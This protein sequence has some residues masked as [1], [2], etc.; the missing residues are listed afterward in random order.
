MSLNKTKCTKRK[1]KDYL[2]GSLLD[3]KFSLWYSSYKIQQKEVFFMSKSNTSS[4]F[5]Q[6][7]AMLRTEMGLTQAELAEELSIF[8]NREKQLSNLTISSYEKG[9]KTPPL[10]MVVFMAKY[11][12]CSTDYLLGSEETDGKKLLVKRES[13]SPL[14]EPDIKIRVQEFRKYHNNPVFVV[15]SNST[16]QNCWAILD[17]D[18]RRLVTIDALYPLTPDITLY[19]FKPLESQYHDVSF[20]QPLTLPEVLKEETV[21]IEMLSTDTFIKGRYNGWYTHNEDKTLLINRTNNL[22]LKYDGCGIA[23]NAYRS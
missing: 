11:F 12:N 9:N 3:T 14:A 15:F 2:E 5:G 16:H 7:L 20:K 13:D 8:S 1:V 23:F 4:I 17:F 6:R 19:R 21:W 10:S 22:M 18:R